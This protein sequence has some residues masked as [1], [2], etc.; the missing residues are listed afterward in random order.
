MQQDAKQNSFERMRMKI[1]ESLSFLRENKKELL[2]KKIEKLTQEVES[3]SYIILFGS[4]ARGEEKAPS[5]LD[6]LVL[7]EQELPR[8]IRGGFSSVFEEE[9]MDLIFYTVK[10]FKESDCLL[11]SQIRKE[12]IVVWKQK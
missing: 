1:D 2:Q 7:T 12:G 9:N 11:V 8:E 6:I 4:Y 5:D 3:I 10:Q